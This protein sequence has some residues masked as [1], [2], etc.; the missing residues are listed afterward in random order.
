VS[1]H[2]D[3]ELL[4]DALATTGVTGASFAYWDG[5]RLH[6]AVAGLRNSVTRDP[7]TDDTLMHAGSITKIM[8][9]ALLMQL[10][11]DGLVALEDPVVR[12]LPELRIRDA[13]ALQR[14]TVQMLVNHTSGID[15]DWV[16]ERGPDEERIVDAV[17]G[18]AD[19][20]QLFQP[21]DATSYNN[22]ATVIAGYLT[23]RL[24]GRSWY[25]LAAERIYAPLGM[26]H[27]LVDPILVP[28]F[29]VSVGD[30]TDPVTGELRQTTRP[31]LSPAFAPAGST[32]MS[33]ASDLVTF[34]RAMIA[35]GL[36]PNGARILSAESAR[37]MREPTAAFVEFPS[38]AVRVGLG[39]MV[40]PGGVVHHGGGG[41][42]V[43]SHFYAH[44][45]SG[46]VAA[47]L[48]NCDRRAALRAPVLDPIIRSWTGIAPSAV[49][50]VADVD[51][52]PYPGVYES[53]VDRYEVTA[54]G[55]GLSLRE[56]SKF[57]L[58]DNLDGTGA[59]AVT[60][61]LHALGGDAFELESSRPGFTGG[62][63]RFVHPEADGT[64]RY[65]A[66]GARLLRRVES[67]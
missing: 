15:G 64:F 5:E 49:T 13:D 47:L 31:F 3:S 46:R 20:G 18:C 58:Y 53:V 62:Q 39:W 36:G 51:T 50:R 48:T 23:Q 25:T 52:R 37:R 33:T 6:T 17:E 11:D 40:S 60:A 67:A 41:P 32:Q 22:L 2:D 38:S 59:T 9:T 57:D 63:I 43:D 55:N 61:T 34:G 45:E 21:G 27:A 42:G 19:L 12:H 24:R 66:S 65:L 4:Q 44:P 8:N 28:R 7:V 10:V 14:I 56:T 26:R 16:P 35:D 30:L 54:T 29:R 1:H